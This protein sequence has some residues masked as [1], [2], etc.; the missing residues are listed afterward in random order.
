MHTRNVV[1]VLIA[2]ALLL[3]SVA[4]TRGVETAQ[5][6][7]PAPAPSAGPSTPPTPQREREYVV[8]API[9]VEEQVDLL[10]QRDGVVTK[11]YADLGK[12]VHKGELLARLDSSQLEADRAALEHNLRADAANVKFHETEQSVNTADLQRAQKMFSAGLITQ[13]QLEHTRFLRDATVWQINHESENQQQDEAK[14]RSLDLEIAKMRIVAPFDGV[15][16]RRYI[17]SGQKVAPND[18]LFW[19][20]AEK[21]LLV[22][23]TLPQEYLLTVKKG[24]TVAVA[25]PFA[26]NERHSAR[27]IAVSPVVDPSSGTI[28]VVARLVGATGTLR[29][30]MT[31]KVHV[32]TP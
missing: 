2:L 23:F 32:P 4:C 22:R 19:I 15:V 12:R 17:R 11:I 27:V 13:E 21:P 6:A 16:G 10:A 7:G 1:P 24:A 26:D 3:A 31:A 30:G 9:M 8:A 28:E 14:T 25:A 5:A 20:T 29:P 18:R